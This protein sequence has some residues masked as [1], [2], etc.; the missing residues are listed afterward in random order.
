MEVPYP[1]VDSNYFQEREGVYRVATILNKL[2]LIFRETPNADVGIDGMV[3][4]V[5]D[6]EQATGKIVAVQI[7]SGISF[8]Q[9]ED[10][11]YY[12]FYPKK[13]H[14]SYWENFP[15]PVILLLHH[16]DNDNIY[17][18]DVRYYLKNSQNL[19]KPYVTIDKI[20]I[21]HNKNNIFYTLGLN[22]Q[23]NTI[24][25][26]IK[27][28]S[29]DDILSLMNKNKFL[30]PDEIDNI[31]TFLT[32]EELLD[33][34][35]NKK[36]K[37]LDFNICFFDLF[38]AGMTN[39]G[40]HLFFNMELAQNLAEIFNTTDTIGI[41]Q[42]EHN[43]LHQYA[44]FLLNQ[45]L[46]NIDYSSYLI[47][48]NERY[49]QPQFLAPLTNRGKIFSQFIYEESKNILDSESY[50]ISECDISLLIFNNNTKIQQMKEFKNKYSK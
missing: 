44:K 3:E 32:N 39:L 28:K 35:I 43:F 48:W 2:G 27:T 7:K 33:F 15:V 50:I 12:K 34:M 18:I 10:K 20:N 16:P 30:F 41:G 47:D 49:L 38:L 40:S 45:N 42:E 31:N 24:E 36:N 8:F 17:Y 22:Y 1:K 21:I 37:A 23:N 25:Q 26:I 9:N 29:N 14:L 13:K 6:E 11:E 19:N 46:A 5:S 4:Y